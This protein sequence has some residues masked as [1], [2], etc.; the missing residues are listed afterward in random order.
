MKNVLFKSGC[1]LLIAVAGTLLPLSTVHADS[2]DQMQGSSRQPYY[3]QTPDATPAFQAST[4][5]NL[6]PQGPIRSDSADQASG[7]ANPNR[8]WEDKSIDRSYDPD[9]SRTLMYGGS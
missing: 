4:M 1:G 5:N 6:G 7:S 2:S 9:K 3:Y 8:S